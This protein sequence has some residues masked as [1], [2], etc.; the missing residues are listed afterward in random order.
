MRQGEPINPLMER[1]ESLTDAGRLDPTPPQG[2]TRRTRLVASALLALHLAALVIAPCAVE[3][4]SFLFANCWRVFRPYLDA[5]YLNHGYHFF[6]P[7]PGPS[8]LVRYEL[9]L[10]DG[11]IRT[12]RFPSLDQQWPRLLYHRHFMM[13]EHLNML[14]EAGGDQKLLEA[15]SESFGRHLLK[16]H[17]ARSVKI[18]LVRHLIAHPND[19]LKG[20]KLTDPKLHQERLLGTYQAGA[21]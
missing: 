8:H 6:A 21:S 13:S 12:G 19:F 20:Q 1:P 9:E 2:W 15:C 3:P 4:S 14:A 7:E 17:S 11:T 10:A 18:Y 16:T 5:A